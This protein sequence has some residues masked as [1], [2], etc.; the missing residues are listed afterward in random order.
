MKLRIRFSPK[1]TIILAGSRHA[2]SSVLFDDFVVL[3]DRVW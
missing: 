2:R 1:Y 3:W